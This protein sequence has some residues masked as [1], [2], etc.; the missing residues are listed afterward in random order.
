MYYTGTRPLYYNGC[1]VLLGLYCDDSWNWFHSE[2]NTDRTGT[3]KVGGFVCILVVAWFDRSAFCQDIPLVLSIACVSVYVCTCRCLQQS[4]SIAPASLYFS[5][6]GYCAR[7]CQILTQKE[8]DDTWRGLSIMHCNS[9][10]HFSNSDGGVR[11]WVDGAFS[12]NG[13]ASSIVQYSTAQELAQVTEK[14]QRNPP[15]APG[16]PLPFPPGHPR[17]SVVERNTT[18]PPLY[19]LTDISLRPLSLSLS[20]PLHLIPRP[21]LH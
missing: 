18:L 16:Y 11:F 1:L 4:Q 3:S 8:S 14:S 19:C 17:I 12:P 6:H 15:R 20:V 10:N 21:H 5:T 7:L 13:I 9:L 2:I